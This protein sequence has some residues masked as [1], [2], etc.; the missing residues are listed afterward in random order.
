MI[1]ECSACEWTELHEIWRTNMSDSDI[2]GHR[3]ALTRDEKNKQEETK[4]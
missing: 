3:F 2:S 4:L 1:I